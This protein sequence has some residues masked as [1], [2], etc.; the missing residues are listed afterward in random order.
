M[1]CFVGRVTLDAKTIFERFT[2][3]SKDDSQFIVIIY[4]S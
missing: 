4:D 2:L 1:G 3:D